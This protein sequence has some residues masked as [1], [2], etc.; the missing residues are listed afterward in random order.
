[1]SINISAIDLTSVDGLRNFIINH[2]KLKVD[3]RE[4]QVNDIVIV[5]WEYSNSK[6]PGQIISIT[7]YKSAPN[8]TNGKCYIVNMFGCLT[9]GCGQ[10]NLYRPN[11]V[12]Y[13][14]NNGLFSDTLNGC[15]M[16]SQKSLELL[17]PKLV[18]EQFKELL[19][20]NNIPFHEEEQKVNVISSSSSNDK[21]KPIIISE[22]DLNTVEGLRDFINNYPK[23]FNG[24][25]KLKDHRFRVNDIVIVN[26]KLNNCKVPGQIRYIKYVS[27][28]EI[29]GVHIFGLGE[30]SCYYSDVYLPNELPYSD[31]EGLFSKTLD[32]YKMNSQRTLELHEPKLVI[33]QFKELLKRNNIPFLEKKEKEEEKKEVECLDN[34]NPPIIISEIDLSTVQALRKF[35]INYPKLSNKDQDFRE[36][37]IVLVRYYNN[38]VPGQIVYVPN[39]KEFTTYGVYCFGFGGND[40]S[41]E[42]IYRLGEIPYSLDSGLFAE[43]WNDYKTNKYPSM[44]H[45][46]EEVIARFRELLIKNNIKFYENKQEE[47]KDLVNNYIQLNKEYR[48]PLDKVTKRDFPLFEARIKSLV[49]GMEKMEVLLKEKI[50]KV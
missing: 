35:V 46:P 19:K 6:L 15:L 29:H 23:P 16:N 4:F 5:D 13:S 40:Y 27:G 32:G 22:I 8:N 30:D 20:R 21:K 44:L 9:L 38:L 42:D 25:R 47:F 41:K 39:N 26:D 12:P 34:T 37:D 11:E 48:T 14:S 49:E 43:K 50:E 28:L 10:D 1:M 24:V 2:P 3:D 18:V 45:N 36:N 31:N 7:N 17:E 33:E